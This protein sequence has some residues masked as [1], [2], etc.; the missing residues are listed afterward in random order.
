MKLSFSG[1]CFD[2]GD[3]SANNKRMNIVGALVSV[4]CL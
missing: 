2:S 4:D 1:K 3:R